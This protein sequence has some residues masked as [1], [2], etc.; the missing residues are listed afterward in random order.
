MEKYLD[1]HKKE[2]RPAQADDIAALK[3]HV[4]VG[5][6]G[7]SFKIEIAQDDETQTILEGYEFDE[8]AKE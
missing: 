1:R 8:N 7:D 6:K 3:G 2:F 5:P 4:G